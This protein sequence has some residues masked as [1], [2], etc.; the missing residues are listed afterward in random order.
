MT[1]PENAREAL[2]LMARAEAMAEEARALSD[3]NLHWLRRRL[4]T[5]RA[6]NLI[7]EAE[8]LSDRACILVGVRATSRLQPKRLGPFGRAGW[9]RFQWAVGIINAYGAIDALYNGH[10]VLAAISVLCV[11]VC[12]LWVLPYKPKHQQP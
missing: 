11:I 5:N 6:Y 12:A 4:N 10:W 9:Q 1:T 3:P 2:I 8:E 7:C